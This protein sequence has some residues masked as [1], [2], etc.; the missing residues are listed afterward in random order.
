MV[1]KRR[2]LLKL[3]I[4]EL[5]GMESLEVSRVVG[6]SICKLGPKNSMP[7][8]FEVDVTFFMHPQLLIWVATCPTSFPR[9]HK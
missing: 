4:N 7:Q 1:G 6:V 5:D 9:D 2:S 8:V 3:K